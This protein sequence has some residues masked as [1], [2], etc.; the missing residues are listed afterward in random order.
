MPAQAYT[1]LAVRFFYFGISCLGYGYAPKIGE[2]RNAGWDRFT[3]P[4]EGIDVR[5]G[6]AFPRTNKCKG[7]VRCDWVASSKLADAGCRPSRAK[8]SR[9]MW[10]IILL[11]LLSVAN[12]LPMSL[13]V[14]HSSQSSSFYFGHVFAYHS[15]GS[16]L[17]R[18]TLP[19]FGTSTKIWPIKTSTTIIRRLRGCQSHQ[20]QVS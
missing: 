7:T 19:D 18:A 17:G 12:S 9:M 10:V 15:P 14:V 6:Q 20:S 16:V 8:T 5:S 4:F 2:I 3:T 13:L 1:S 11:A